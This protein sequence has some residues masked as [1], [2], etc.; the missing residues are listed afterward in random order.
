MGG[1]GPQ[2]QTGGDGPQAQTVFG[3]SFICSELGRVVRLNIRVGM[4]DQAGGFTRLLCASN[5]NDIQSAP[6]ASCP[7]NWRHPIP[8]SMATANR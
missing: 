3:L 1:D 8:V 6:R 7:H 5:N 2:A 4:A